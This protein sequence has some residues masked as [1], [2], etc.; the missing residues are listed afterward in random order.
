[1]RI[2]GRKLA[3]ILNQLAAAVKPGITTGELEEMALRLIKK[4]GGRPSFKG[5]KSKF[6]R[7][8]FPTALCSSINSE[9]VH[10]PAL[11]SRVLKEGD[12]VGLDLGLK[13]KGYYTDMS[14]TVGVGKI[15]EEAKKLIS[16]AKE[17][18]DLAVKKVKPG[19]YLNEIGGAIQNFIE[20]RGFSVVRE[21]VGHG[22][23]KYVHE[24]PKVPN[25]ILDE[26]S[27][28]KLEP[29]MVI[30]IEPMVNIGS[31]KI[32]T[33]SDDFTIL[34]ADGSLSAHWEHTVA[35]LEEG[36]EILTHI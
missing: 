11:P 14:I 4:A 12:I 26:V 36:Y 7:T 33:A 18:L 8:S 27:D 24:D 31:Y 3:E 23:G 9:I 25:Y 15:S 29:G 1:M 32:K 10:A 17:S 35:V 22:V 6:D 34:T 5:Y 19:A 28:I 21:L 16:A 13:Y 30:A 20:E 2:G